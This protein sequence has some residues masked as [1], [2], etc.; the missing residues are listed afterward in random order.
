[1]AEAQICNLLNVN[2][3]LTESYTLGSTAL[4]LPVAR[5][6]SRLPSNLRARCG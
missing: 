2:T 3:V 1:M 6:A 5:A 4:S